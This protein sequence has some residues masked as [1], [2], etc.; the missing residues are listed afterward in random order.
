MRFFRSVPRRA[1]SPVSEQ[2][3]A[4]LW[5]LQWTAEFEFDRALEDGQRQQVIEGP[6]NF[7]LLTLARTCVYVRADVRRVY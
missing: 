2:Q 5:P 6:A 4:D 1:P 3:A 7:L